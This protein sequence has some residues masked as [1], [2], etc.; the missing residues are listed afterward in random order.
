MHSFQTVDKLNVDFHCDG[1]FTSSIKC[2]LGFRL[3]DMAITLDH[4][5]EEL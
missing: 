1:Y 2:L 5:Y 4:T 3:H